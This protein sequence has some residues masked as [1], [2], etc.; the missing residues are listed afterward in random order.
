MRGLLLSILV[1][2]GFSRFAQTILELLRAT[3]ADELERVVIVDPAAAQ[4]VRQF[5]ADVPLD[6][7]A[8]STVDGDP[9]DPGTWTGV[10]EILKDTHIEPVYLLASTEEV[11]NFRAAMLLRGRSAKPR[12]F[13]RCFHRTRFA[14]S[15]ANQ[16]SFELL[17][18]EDVLGEALREHYEALREV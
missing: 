8:Y 4:K 7:L 14:E 3:A 16:L 11:V 2:G 13:A 12:V 9:E 18:F 1:I 10:D 17:A 15:L 6:A 5:G